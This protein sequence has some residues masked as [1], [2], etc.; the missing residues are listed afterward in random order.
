M[1]LALLIGLQGSGKSSFR[2]DRL[3]GHVVVSL[4]L[5][6]NNSRPRR[7]QHQFIAA[8]LSEGRSVVVD[9]TSPTVADRAPLIALG[10]AFG[11]RVVGYFL[12][13]DLDDCLRRNALRQGRERVPDVALYATAKRLRPPSCGEGFDRLW[14]VR[15]IEGDGWEVD[16]WEEE[17]SDDEAL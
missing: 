2:R 4:D 10:I 12:A 9:N 16:D 15:L 1:E 3:A 14:R 5:L 11:A 13:A 7:R 8:A 17:A 6:R